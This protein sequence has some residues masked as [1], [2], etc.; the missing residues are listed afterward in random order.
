M[1]RFL[2]D[3]DIPRAIVRG[4]KRRKGRLRKVGDVTR[5]VEEVSD[6]AETLRWGLEVIDD[7]DLRGIVVTPHVQC[8]PLPLVFDREGVLR[9]PVLLHDEMSEWVAVKTQYAP[10]DIHICLIKLVRHLERRYPSQAC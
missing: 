4:A 9:N 7:K 2:A 8:E 5:L 10:V 1:A 6:I 3:E